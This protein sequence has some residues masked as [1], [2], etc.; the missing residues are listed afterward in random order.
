MQ[1][2]LQASWIFQFC[3]SFS[4]KLL[5]MKN[6]REKYEEAAHILVLI[7]PVIDLFL[8]NIIERFIKAFW[9]HKRALF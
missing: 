8:L 3:S 4:A 9:K 7:L 2:I 5:H 1:A 6:I